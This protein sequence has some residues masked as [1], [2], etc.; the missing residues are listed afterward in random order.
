MS[1]KHFA[2]VGDPWPFKNMEVGDVAIC[3]DPHAPNRAHAY[4]HVTGKRFTSRKTTSKSGKEGFIIVR[5]DDNT[6]KVKKGN[7][8]LGRP[9]TVW[10]YETLELGTS[11]HCVDPLDA[12][13]VVSSVHRTNAVHRHTRGKNTYATRVIRND[14][15][16]YARVIVTRIR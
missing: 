5:M 8:R 6:P 15:L 10:P 2:G 14:D 1:T 9:R 12:P 4:G 3:L 16:T 11:W 7:G 13:K